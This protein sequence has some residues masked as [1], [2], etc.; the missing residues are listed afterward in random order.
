MFKTFS[1][2]DI[3]YSSKYLLSFLSMTVVRIHV[4]LI[5]CTCVFISRL[6]RLKVNTEFKKNSVYCLLYIF[7]ISI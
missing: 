1:E 3:K 6:T 5:F 2:H 7:I 4:K